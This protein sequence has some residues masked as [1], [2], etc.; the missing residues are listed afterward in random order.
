M[1]ARTPASELQLSNFRTVCK[2]VGRKGAEGRHFLSLL[3][4]LKAYMAE[5]CPDMPLW[6]LSPCILSNFAV[7]LQIRSSKE[8][9]TSVAPRCIETFTGMQ[10]KLCLP[11]LTD[12]PHLS[13]VPSHQS[14]GDG[15]TGHVPLDIIPTLESLCFDA[16][17]ESAR[18]VS[19]VAMELIYG[20]A[21]AQD[22]AMTS[23]TG[24]TAAPSAD[25]VY[26]ISITKNGERNTRF[27]LPARGVSR[28][29]TW[30]S[31]FHA[32]LQRFGPIPSFS[33]HIMKPDSVLK[34]GVHKDPV[35]A[36]QRALDTI[37]IHAAKMRGYSEAELKAMHV[38]PHS[39]HGSFG[40]Y[41]EAMEWTIPRQYAI[42]RWKLPLVT[43]GAAPPSK[44]KRGGSMG[45]KTIVAVYSTAAACQKQLE[46]RS[47][48]ISTLAQCDLG[49]KMGASLQAIM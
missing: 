25:V 1:Y 16:P 46:L 2:A 43:A 42:G 22:W 41:S 14:S 13:A 8:D 36:I 28:D 23:V 45:P 17:S 15:F 5:R 31:E 19:R 49:P 48:M 9:A 27:A 44:R 24:K 20:S 6:P 11:V 32:H 4:K 21:R 30:R 40:A 39:L 38:S 26:I 18:F 34:P 37:L 12:S 33:K 47:E 29:P 10:R 3:S 35:K 7:H